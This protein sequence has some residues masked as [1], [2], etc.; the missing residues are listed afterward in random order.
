MATT[1]LT[2]SI[3][4]P[5]ARGN[6][7]CHL[8]DLTL[9]SVAAPPRYI[10]V[11]FKYETGI[12]ER[13]LLNATRI[14]YTITV[15]GDEGQLMNIRQHYTRIMAY[16]LQETTITLLRREHAPVQIPTEWAQ[17][18]PTFH[19]QHGHQTN[20][21]GHLEIKMAWKQWIKRCAGPIIVTITLG[22]WGFL[23][24]KDLSGSE[25]CSLGNS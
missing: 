19:I 21:I 7:N 10:R 13:F 23:I 1:D 11:E 16:F 12:P 18:S 25:D 20:N 22:L 5:R 4:S 15:N 8:R 14:H 2:P 9:A 3:T 6:Q 24:T 17:A